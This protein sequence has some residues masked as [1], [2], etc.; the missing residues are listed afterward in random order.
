MLGVASGLTFGLLFAPKKGK[1][2]RTELFTN[3]NKDVA[4]KLKTLGEAYIDAGHDLYNEMV[5]LSEHEEVAAALSKSQAKIRDFLADADEHADDFEYAISKKI[6]K[7]LKTAGKK[8]SA[9]KKKVEKK[10][11]EGMKIVKRKVRK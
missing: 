6:D 2:L 8:V 5:K 1:Q 7:T 9:A 3:N 4:E 11:K 10:V